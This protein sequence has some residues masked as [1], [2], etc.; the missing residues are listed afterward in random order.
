MDEIV[1]CFMSYGVTSHMISTSGKN[2]WIISLLDRVYV[3]YVFSKIE[4]HDLPVVEVYSQSSDCP[5]M[6]ALNVL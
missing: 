2:D 4:I 5:L 1:D 3:A 6:F